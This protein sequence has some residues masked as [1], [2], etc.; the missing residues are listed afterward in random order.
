MLDN[1]RYKEC[2]VVSHHSTLL[3]NPQNWDSDSNA[4]RARIVNPCWSRCAIAP[5]VSYLRYRMRAYIRYEIKIRYTPF[6]QSTREPRYPW[7]APDRHSLLSAIWKE[8]EEPEG[9][10]R[11]GTI[12]RKDG[13]EM[14]EATSTVF[15]ISLFRGR[16]ENGWVQTKGEKRAR[17]W[18]AGGKDEINSR[19]YGALKIVGISLTTWQTATVVVLLAGGLKCIDGRSLA[20]VRVNSCANASSGYHSFALERAARALLM[21]V[22]WNYCGTSRS[23]GR[24]A[25]WG[26]KNARKGRRGESTAR[27]STDGRRLSFSSGVARFLFPP[28][29]PS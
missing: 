3:S 4:R 10:R 7:K 15:Q 27:N 11:G 25:R 14:E 29:P 23:P 26:L 18:K 8:W 20:S 5:E 24:C 1:P 9:G 12:K 13:T 2:N 17:S 19:V 6:N 28:R 16:D 21:T 22:P